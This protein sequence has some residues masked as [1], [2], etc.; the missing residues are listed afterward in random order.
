MVSVVRNDR[1]MF[2]RPAPVNLADNGTW[3]LAGTVPGVQLVVRAAA[4]TLNGQLRRRRSRHRPSVGI[5]GLALWRG[6]PAPRCR[7]LCM[8]R[9]ATTPASE[10]TFHQ[11]YICPSVPTQNRRDG[12]AGRG[13][14]NLPCPVSWSESRMSMKDARHWKLYTPLGMYGDVMY[15]IQC[16][17]QTSITR[18]LWPLILRH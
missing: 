11:Y 13:A 18:N 4:A 8:H 16:I 6:H 2:S 3:C 7:A 10:C 9:T 12:L 1:S 5:G 15:A 14:P 17:K